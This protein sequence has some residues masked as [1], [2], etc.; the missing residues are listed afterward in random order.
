M[1]FPC[2]KGLKLAKRLG[3][4]FQSDCENYVPQKIKQKI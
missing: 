4:D 1:F 3:A 2:Q